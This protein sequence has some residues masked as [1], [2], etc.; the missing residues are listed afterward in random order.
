MCFINI[1]VN[2]MSGKILIQYH[3]VNTSPT[4]HYCISHHSAHTNNFISQDF[5]NYPF[6]A[7]IL[8]LK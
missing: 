5:Y 2:I 1:N 6:L 7:Y 8:L 3:T 4:P